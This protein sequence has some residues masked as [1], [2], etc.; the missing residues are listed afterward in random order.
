MKLIR[1]KKC[2]RATTPLINFNIVTVLLKH[3]CQFFFTD[4]SKIFFCLG[5]NFLQWL[6]DTFSWVYQLKNVF[7]G[8]LPSW[9]RA[10]MRRLKSL[11]WVECSKGLD[12]LYQWWFHSGRLMNSPYSFG[13]GLVNHCHHLHVC[14]VPVRGNDDFLWSKNIRLVFLSYFDIFRQTGEIILE[15]NI[16]ICEHSVTNDNVAIHGHRIIIYLSRLFCAAHPGLVKYC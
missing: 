3:Q 6:V 12:L 9:Q 14:P 15:T 5:R 16:C 2:S 10:H 4:F 1:L 11:A 7:P 8:I 13:L